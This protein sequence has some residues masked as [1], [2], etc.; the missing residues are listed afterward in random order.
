MA[1]RCPEL[2]A[3]LSWICVNCM[4]AGALLGLRDHVN[5]VQL[6]NEAC[7]CLP[8]PQA[9]LNSCSSPGNDPASASR[10]RAAELLSGLSW[11]SRSREGS[12]LGCRKASLW[13]R[14]KK[15]EW[16]TWPR[17]GKESQV[18]AGFR[19]PMLGPAGSFCSYVILPAH[20]GCTP[21][22]R[23]VRFKHISSS[24]RVFHY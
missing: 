10:T 15:P 14:G 4:V 19:P 5:D 9:R 11:G 16:V 22:P 7:V 1:C 2:D 24:N 17:T 12:F 8:H 21:H 13:G 20:P 18:G 6:N 23:Q 3:L